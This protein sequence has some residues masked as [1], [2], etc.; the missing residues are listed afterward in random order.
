MT[1]ERSFDLASDLI[2]AAERENLPLRLLGGQAVRWLCP[3]FPPR[4]R[5]GQDMD[6]A[7]LTSARVQVMEFL[8]GHGYVANTRFNTLHGDRQL[9]FVSADGETL[10]DVIMDRLEMCH[11]LEFKKRLDRLPYTLDITD[12]LLS[13]LQVVQQNAKDV[14]DI[15]YLLAAYPIEDGDRPGTIGLGRFGEIVANDWGW[16]RTATRNLE[17][18]I[19]LATSGES[20]VPAHS[21]RDPMAQTRSLLSFAGAVPK[22][23]K[24]R[25]R[26]KVGDH[27]QWYQLPEDVD[28]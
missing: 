23:L 25:I 8:S 15:V 12:L 16:W 24:W 22:S 2:R 9:S 1:A 19:Q 14:Q 11:V 20:V 13:K 10:I 28:H 18:V 5:E 21:P 7:S 6:F 27:V 3:D 17:R 4:S 26:A